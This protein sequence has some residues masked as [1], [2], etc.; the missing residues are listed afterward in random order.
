[1]R[2]VSERLDRLHNEMIVGAVEKL[3]QLFIER[4][5]V[6]KCPCLISSNVVHPFPLE[7]DTSRMNHIKDIHW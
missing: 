2:I 6:S 1:M 3:Q 4:T 5:N 7:K